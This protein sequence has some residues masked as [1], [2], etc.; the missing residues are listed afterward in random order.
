MQAEGTWI[1]SGGLGALGSL[2]AQWLAAQGR[3]PAESGWDSANQV[4][5]QIMGKKRGFISMLA[6]NLSC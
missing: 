4:Q 5:E 1:I 2:T 6:Q 3:T